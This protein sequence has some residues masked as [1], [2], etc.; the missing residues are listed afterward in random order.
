MGWVLLLASHVTGDISDTGRTKP[1]FPLTLHLLQ[2]S[3]PHSLSRSECPSPGL[4]VHLGPCLPKD[5]CLPPGPVCLR[6][7]SMVFQN[8][9]CCL[10]YNMFTSN[11]MSLLKTENQCHCYRNT[12]HMKTNG[13][14]E[15]AEMLANVPAC[16]RQS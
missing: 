13:R 2:N 16:Q 5:M 14:N 7:I 8:Q 12:V 1:E 3:F 15:Y 4:H 10:T 11:C 6:C 9:A